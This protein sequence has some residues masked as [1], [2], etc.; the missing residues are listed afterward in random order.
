M[1]FDLIKSRPQCSGRLLLFTAHSTQH[2]AQIHSRSHFRVCTGFSIMMHA[3]LALAA[4]S[5]QV[6]A[7]FIDYGYLQFAANSSAPSDG[8]E[9]FQ[10][11]AAD[12][13]ASNTVMFDHDPET[14][15]GQGWT[16]TLAISN[17]SMPNITDGIN[18]DNWEGLSDDTEAHVAFT[19]YSFSWPEEGNVNQAVDPGTSSCLFVV[20]NEFP[21]DISDAWDPS[22]PDC[23]SALGEECVEAIQTQLW[24]EDGDCSA[25]SLS[26]LGD[27][28][29][30]SFASRSESTRPGVIS[31][32]PVG[33]CLYPQQL[34]SR[35]FV[36]GGGVFNVSNRRIEG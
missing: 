24:G 30:G 29:A 26:T 22:S 6:S 35:A 27:A 8:F 19:T 13:E 10:E 9:T 25:G 32:A 23:A 5:A 3:I 1:I 4:L 21:Q 20:M 18:D 7:Q 14:Q 12:P 28:C 34:Q 11:A 36:T 15:T 16:W 31:L 17:V 33:K 2:T